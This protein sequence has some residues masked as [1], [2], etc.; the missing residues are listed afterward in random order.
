MNSGAYLRALLIAVRLGDQ[1]LIQKVIVCTPPAM[2]TSVVATLPSAVI[3][4]IVKSLAGILDNGTPHVEHIISWLHQ[5]C[6]RHGIAIQ[7][8]STQVE[9]VLKG[10]AKSLNQL[11]DDLG[12]LCESNIYS[13]RY[14]TGTK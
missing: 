3:V 5:I 1:D 12:G 14:L 6:A 9:P 4:P 13:L 10:I 8:M 2:V 11:H 7:H